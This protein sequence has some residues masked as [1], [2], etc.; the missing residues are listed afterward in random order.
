MD[1]AFEGA[2]SFALSALCKSD[3]YAWEQETSLEL[4]STILDW[5]PPLCA[6]NQKRHL[7][8]QAVLVGMLFVFQDRH[9]CFY[10]H[11]QVVTSLTEARSSILTNLRAA[12]V[13]CKLKEGLTS[14]C[15]GSLL[16]QAVQLF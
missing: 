12:V 14:C 1:E 16:Y 15:L 2:V 4:V 3:L 11:N 10:A 8:S 9:S 6:S 13:C 5:V 7:V